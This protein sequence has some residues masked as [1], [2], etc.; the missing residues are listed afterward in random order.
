MCIPPTPRLC[1][2]FV[3]QSCL[4]PNALIVRQGFLDRLCPRTYDDLIHRQRP[5]DI[6][7]P[8]RRR[9]RVRSQSSIG[10]LDSP[11]TDIGLSVRFI[12]TAGLISAVSTGTLLLYFAVSP[13]RRAIS[14]QAVSR[15]VS[16]F[17]RDPLGWYMG[18]SVH[19]SESL[20]LCLTYYLA[21]GR[22]VSM[23]FSDF[24]QGSGFVLNLVWAKYS[25][26]WLGPACTAQAGITEFGDVGQPLISILQWAVCLVTCWGSARLRRLRHLFPPHQPSHVCRPFPPQDPATLGLCTRHCILVASHSVHH[27][28]RSGHHRARD[29]QGRLLRQ[30]GRLVLDFDQLPSQSQSVAVA[31]V[32]F[33]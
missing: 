8:G 30:L 3:S 17:L 2:N 14:T 24:C 1:L 25:A 4:D 21:A 12:G 15:G 7:G 9:P 10:A 33:G 23:L 27:V 29:W 22:S 28:G 19:S 18:Q 20:S 5:D 6:H 16:Q 11:S 26:L 13:L 31:P 32:N